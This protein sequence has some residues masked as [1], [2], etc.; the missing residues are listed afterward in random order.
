MQLCATLTGLGPTWQWKA[1]RMIVW[2]LHR[3][4]DLLPSNRGHSK[5]TSL[6]LVEYSPHPT[7]MSNKTI[8]VKGATGSH[9]HQRHVEGYRLERPRHHPQYQQRRREEARRR[10]HRGHPGQLRRRAVPSQ[11]LRSSRESLPS[12][13]WPTG[14]STSSPARRGTKLASWKR[15]SA[16]SSREPRPEH[17]PSSITSGPPRR[18]RRASQTGNCSRRTWTTRPTLTRAIGTSCPSSRLKLHICNLA[19]TR[20]TWSGTPCSGL[21]YMWASSMFVH[22][23]LPA[24]GAQRSWAMTNP[25]QI[26]RGI[27]LS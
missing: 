23:C 15:S 22:Q 19:I 18:A 5:L 26:P 9:P 27:I 12:T 25:C 6:Y 21:P 4:D 10:G 17:P 3:N 14:G 24:A 1:T 16:W 2:Y 11:G 13:A 7:A 8:V 20:R